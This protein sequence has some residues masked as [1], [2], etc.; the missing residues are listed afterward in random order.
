M[1]HT[2]VAT[3]KVVIGRHCVSD[4]LISQEETTRKGLDHP[5]GVLVSR[6]GVVQ[7]ASHHHLQIRVA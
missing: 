3:S 2:F 1:V 7:I 6:G 5:L 4:S